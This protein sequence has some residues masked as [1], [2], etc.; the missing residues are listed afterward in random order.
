MGLLVFGV[1]FLV[2]CADDQ[3]TQ[4]TPTSP[5]ASTGAQPTQEAPRSTAAGTSADA[6]AATPSGPPLQ[7]VATSNIVADW[8]EV[9]GGDRVEV[10][11]L[12]SPGAD[13]HSIVPGVSD[14]AK[15]ADADVV[16]SVG[17]GLEAIWLDDLVHNASADESKLVALGDGV[18]PLE[19]ME[20][21][22]HGH[23][24]H[25][26]HMDEGD[27]HHGEMLMGRLL[28]GDGE[29]GRLSVIDLET[30]EVEQDLFDL[31]SRA[32]R[33][34]ATESGRYAVAVSTDANTVHLFDGGIYLEPHGDHF[35]LIER[36]VRKL[37]ID[38]SGDRPVHMYIGGEWATVYYDGSGDIVLINEHEL[39]KEGDSYMPVRMN[40][41]PH[42]GAVVPL[43]DDL[44][45]VTPQHPNYSQNPEEY[46]LPMG[47]E[48][49]DLDGNVL[50]SAEGCP[51]LHG[52][53]GNG[54]VAVFGCTGGVLMVEAHDGHYEDA[55]ISAP[56]G[57]PEDFRL[58]S[59]WGYHG[60]DHFF[61]LG[62]AV[63][64]YIVETEEGEMEQLI[65]ATENVRPIQVH[66]G[67]GG[68][69]LLVVMSNGE[70]RLYDAHDVELLASNSEFLAT[71]VETGFWARPH[72]ATAPDAIFV[73]DSGGGEVFHLDGHDLEVVEHWHVEGAPTK[74]AFVGIVGEAEGHDEHEEDEHGHADEGDGHHDEHG[75]AHGPLD[76]HFWFDPNRVKIAVNDIAV[77]FAGLD[78]EGASFYYQNA[79]DYAV[80]LDELHS[81]I[82]ERV[83]LVQPERRL[84]V[85]SHDTFAY[86]ADV[87]GFEVIG[88]LIP[89]LAP[90]VEPSADH[91]TGLVDVIREHNAP[92]VF[93]ETT[94][95]GKLPQALAR[96]TGAVF[97][98][99]YADSL[100]E[101]GSAAGTYLGMVRANVER[102]V[103]ALK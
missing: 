8:A 60:L 12:H 40:A 5:G 100:G 91:I 97:A 6:A 52:D 21:G 19:F 46:R 96:E 74:I 62:S 73:T 53:A 75:H 89:S 70:L 95:S 10:F 11:S 81:W 78:P 85:T 48:I 66:L 99:L 34:Y 44:F 90:D 92:A 67:H 14:V 28:I 72:I 42:H 35:D 41:G 50:H 71:P 102:I 58:T 9:V 87:Y 79:A 4:A 84:L 64:L 45:A 94:V 7:V 13:P 55:F 63:G 22:G 88:A 80:Q 86:F 32:G 31:G 82:Q 77:R 103:E 30:G 83:E 27:D 33:I 93:S 65:P 51:D 68:E 38:L 25:D 36:D 59:V 101:K 57:S 16:L 15:V 26:D 2:A 29:A 76:P 61:A 69:S 43:E 17:L 24:D 37:P 54:H 47:A 56:A 49:W 20:M 98:Q 18:D 1:A 39:E 3:D 23:G